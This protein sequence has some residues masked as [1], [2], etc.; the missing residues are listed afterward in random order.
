MSNPVISEDLILFPSDNLQTAEEV[1]TLL[2]ER[3]N[4]NG[5]V[6]ASFCQAVLDREQKFPTGLPTRPYPTAIPH[7]EPTGVTE[8]GIGI[9]ILRRPVPFRSMESPKEIL[10]V[11]IV[12]LLAI[13]GA[14]DQVLMLQWIVTALQDQAMVEALASASDPQEAMATLR[15][16]ID[17]Q[18]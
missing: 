9:A 11:R 12:W 2:C 6:D 5:Y 14:A 7:A 15:P 13:A 17:D 1:I 16:L 10:D 3:L 18:P 8:T 4:A